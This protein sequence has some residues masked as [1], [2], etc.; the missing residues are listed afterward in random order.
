MDRTPEI[1]D[2][3]TRSF[4]DLSGRR[5]SYLDHGGAGRPLLAL[6]GHFGEGRTFARLAAMLRPSWR[7]FAPDQRGHGESDRAAEYSREGYVHDAL[8]LLD[9]LGL[10]RIPVIGHSLGGVN[11]YQLAASNPD[12]V[13]ALV[14]EDIGAVVDSDLSFALGWP[15]RTQSRESLLK[16]LGPRLAPHLVDAFRKYRNGWG[17]AFHSSDMVVSQRSLNG[18]HWSDWLAT[19]CPT[20]LLRGSRSTVLTSEHAAEMASRRGQVDLVELSGGH[21]IHDDQPEAFAAAIAT[22]L[23]NRIQPDDEGALEGEPG[24]CGGPAPTQATQSPMLDD[25][26]PPG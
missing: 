3:P 25:S 4:I 18:D 17:F 10:S 15:D 22:F 26:C 5:L 16:I 7:V 11:A 14:I 2:T 21:V 19:N 24:V 12:R 6:H 23:D 1:S 13:S 9:H 8:A 20:L